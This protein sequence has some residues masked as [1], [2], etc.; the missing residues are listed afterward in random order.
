M[1]TKEENQKRLRELAGLL[2]READM[3]V[4]RI[5]H[6]VWQSG[7]RRFAPRKMKSQM[8]MIPF[9]SR[10]AGTPVRMTLV[11]WNVSGF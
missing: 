5:S 4:L 8:L 1:A 9:M 7:K 3:S 11:F 2:G 10:H 6:S